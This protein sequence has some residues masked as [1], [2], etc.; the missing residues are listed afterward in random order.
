[1]DAFVQILGYVALGLESTLPI[2]QLV[3]YDTLNSGS[4]PYYSF[5][6]TLFQQHQASHTVRLQDDHTYWLG[7]R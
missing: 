6:L 1:M 7:R 5:V 4:T 2:P 3:R